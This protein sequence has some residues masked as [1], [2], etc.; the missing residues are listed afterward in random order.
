METT[1]N[2]NKYYD[3]DGI[4]ERVEKLITE[5][6]HQMNAAQSKINIL[7]EYYQ[8]LVNADTS[9]KKLDDQYA[10][11]QECTECIKKD[12][13]DEEL[14]KNREMVKSFFYENFKE[15][16]KYRAEFR[17]MDTKLEKARI[18]NLNPTMPRKSPI[19][20]ELEIFH[21]EVD[22]LCS[23]ILGLKLDNNK[24]EEK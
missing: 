11:M 1:D 9:I 20:D 15:E 18:P 12:P 6:T 16:K 2:K 21:K 17:A 5:Y 24:N 4:K 8:K 23:P 13:E 3:M 22:K 10:L 19:F 14:V 7:N